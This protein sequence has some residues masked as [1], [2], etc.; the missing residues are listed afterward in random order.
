[1][2]AWYEVLAYEKL[3]V[4]VGIRADIVRWMPVNSKNGMLNV[5]ECLEKSLCPC[6]P[7]T[8]AFVNT[9]SSQ[10]S[11]IRRPSKRRQLGSVPSAEGFLP[12]PITACDAL[13]VCSEVSA[14]T[15][16]NLARPYL[17]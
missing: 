1:M 15:N 17:C 16:I 10:E 3:T 7:Q 4:V 12:L 5:L 6:L 8:E 14:L 9:C 11:A 13:D 2:L